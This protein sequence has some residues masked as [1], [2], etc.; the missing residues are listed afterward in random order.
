MN[1]IKYEIGKSD[2][3]KLFVL[4]ALY[5][6]VFT[7]ALVYFQMNGKSIAWF[8][9][10]TF[11]WLVISKDSLTRPWTLLTHAITEGGISI[12]ISNY[13]W[14]YFFGFIIE[15]LRGRYS[16]ISL[17]LVT[18]LVTGI[19]AT[20]LCYVLPE[21]VRGGYYF[22]M[23]SCV[24][25]VAS[26]A[27]FF[28]PSYRVFHFIQGGIPI[29]VVGIVF[30]LLSMSAG[31]GDMANIVC[32][33]IAI[34]LG[35]AYNTVLKGFFMHV[36]QRLKGLSAMGNKKVPAKRQATYTKPLGTKVISIEQTKIDKLL[37][38]INEQGIASLTPEEKQWLDTYSQQR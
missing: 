26:A 13:I 32:M 20:V 35:Y 16:V 36:Q 18:A 9:T 22:G 4:S 29:W 21:A 1:N 2:V 23:R 33:L 34:G 8:Q 5:M 15:D 3:L 25:A 24:V 38:K 19:V 6:G 37:D 28:S 12:F 27:V 17:M 11:P 10:Q 14:L 31:S 7:M 30:L